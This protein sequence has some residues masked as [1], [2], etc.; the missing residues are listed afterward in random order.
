MP[1]RERLGQPFAVAGQVAEP[2]PQGEAPSGA[3]VPRSAR[4]RGA[5]APWQG[6]GAG[7]AP[8]AGWI[9]DKKYFV[10]MQY[11]L[12]PGWSAPWD[13]PAGP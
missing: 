13:R 5:S 2:A 12:T 3:G 8:S 4:R 9:L 7:F 10:D 11:R 1:A 6:G